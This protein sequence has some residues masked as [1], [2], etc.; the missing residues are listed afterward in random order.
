MKKLVFIIGI[1]SAA[2]AIAN[3]GCFDGIHFGAGLGYHISD[4]VGKIFPGSESISTKTS[5]LIGTVLFGTGRTS[6][7]YPLYWGGEILMDFSRTQHN[8]TTLG[9]QKIKIRDNGLMPSCG[10][11]LG[12]AAEEM[13]TMFFGKFG[14]AYKKVI[15]ENNNAESLQKHS[16]LIP[17]LAMGIEK[18]VFGSSTFRFDIEYGMKTHKDSDAYGLE[19]G[20]H[21]NMRVMIV[22]HVRF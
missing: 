19:C 11:R 7:A 2:P 16:K 6:N 9:G 21:F 20:P 5:R 17:I 22:H 3:S 4:N 14:M 12:C 18:A 10:F 8:D 15:I 13:G 1:F